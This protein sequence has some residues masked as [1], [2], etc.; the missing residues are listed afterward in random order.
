MTTLEPQAAWFRITDL[1]SFVGS[2]HSLF[3]TVHSSKCS[4]TLRWR[5]LRLQPSF[6]NNSSS[7]YDHYRRS[8]TNAQIYIVW[9]TFLSFWRIPATELRRDTASSRSRKT[10]RVAR[11]TRRRAPPLCSSR[12][13]PISS[14]AIWSFISRSTRCLSSESCGWR[15]LHDEFTH[16]F[17]SNFS[18]ENG[19]RSSIVPDHPDSTTFFNSIMLE[20]R[21]YEIFSRVRNWTKSI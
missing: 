7:S 13:A 10:S 9:R 17:A 1:Q 4:Y 20:R 18:S 3:D 12:D 14:E 15:A 5:S 2:L 16:R 8:K 6:S 11:G 21:S 19:P